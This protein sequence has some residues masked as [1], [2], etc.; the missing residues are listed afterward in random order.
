MLEFLFIAA[1]CKKEKFDLK[2]FYSNEQRAQ[3][4]TFIVNILL[5]RI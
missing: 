3:F 5:S 2:N 1:Y 4:R